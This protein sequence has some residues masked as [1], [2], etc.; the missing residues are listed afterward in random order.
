MVHELRMKNNQH[1][2]ILANGGNAT[3]QH[4]I[5][6]SSQPRKGG[7]PYP[8]KNPLPATITDVPAPKMDQ[9]A[10]GEAMVETYTVEFKRDGSPLR[11][12]VVGRLRSNGHRFIAND[13]DQVTLQ[14]LT[15][16]VKEQIGR[17]GWVRKDAE[18]AGRNLFSFEASAKI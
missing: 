13:G 16:T 8:E 17:I 12:H 9:E 4:V 15:S 2:L 10:E 1:G 18:K 6:L 14:Q 11:G 7:S 3:Y 5:C